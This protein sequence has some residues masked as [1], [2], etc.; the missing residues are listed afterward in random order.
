MRRRLEILDENWPSQDG[1]E[2]TAEDPITHVKM[3]RKCWN[4]EH[5]KGGCKQQGCEC[6]CYDGLNS[7]T[8]GL[9]K[10]EEDQERFKVGTIPV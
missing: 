5:T 3:C 10:P 7:S 2:L 8:T 9:A 6:P 4:G 1:K